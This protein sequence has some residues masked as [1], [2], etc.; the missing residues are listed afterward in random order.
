[1]LTLHRVRIKQN[2]VTMSMCILLIRRLMYMVIF[3][4]QHEYFYNHAAWRNKIFY[5]DAVISSNIL[6]LLE[7]D[8][9]YSNMT[10]YVPVN[11]NNNINWLRNLVFLVSVIMPDRFLIPFSYF[12]RF[13]L[14]KRNVVFLLFS[15][16][17][18]FISSIFL[19]CFV[20]VQFSR[21]SFLI[22]RHFHLA[23]FLEIEWNCASQ[24]SWIM[25][26]PFRI[27]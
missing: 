4:Y 14:Q 16:S 15:S 12:V 19:C 26:L 6:F 21:L 24:I 2:G 22:Y 3:V 8:R 9:I 27:E 25:N 11:V 18:I 5:K 10:V 1:M 20:F 13:L 23:G 17:G 7:Y